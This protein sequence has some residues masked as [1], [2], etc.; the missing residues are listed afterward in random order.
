MEIS[1]N[2]V[3]FSEYMNFKNVKYVN[4]KNFLISRTFLT[5]KMLTRIIVQLVGFLLSLAP[6]LLMFCRLLKNGWR[7]TFQTRPHSMPAVLD[8]PKHG[9]H[10]FVK[11]GLISEVYSYF[12]S[13]SMMPCASI[14]LKQLGLVQNCFGPAYKY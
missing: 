11:G 7:H 10:G 1:Q 3:A 13:I 4:N 6:M 14:G 8:D 5:D 9:T 12:S 2:F